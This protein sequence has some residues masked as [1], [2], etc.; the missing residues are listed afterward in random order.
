MFLRARW[1]WITGICFTLLASSLGLAVP[2]GLQGEKVTLDQLVA[3]HLESIGQPQA[4]AAAK[5]RSVSGPIK[6]TSRI[7]R[8]GL[9]DGKGVIASAGS[10]LRYSMGFNAPDYPTEQMAFDG[11]KITTSFLP[12]GARSQLSQFLDQQSIPLREGLLCGALSSSWAFLRLDQLQ[13]QLQYKGLNRVNGRQLHEIAYKAK[14]GSSDLKVTVYFEPDTFRHVLTT[15]KFQIGA[16]L[17]VG[18]NDSNRIG[19]SYYTLNEEYGDFRVVEGLTLPYKYKLQLSV[20]T[21]N[22]TGLM[23]WVLSVEKVS[24]NDTFDEKLFRIDKVS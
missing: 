3:R 19:D 24:S 8:V 7:G 1:I 4:R 14:K 18:P 5:T 20:E 17:G 23:D 9:L 22:G 13:P 16:R 6:M 11:Q 12:K 10:K 15:Y 21:S 2:A